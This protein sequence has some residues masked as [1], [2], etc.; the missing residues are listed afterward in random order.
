MVYAERDVITDAVRLERSRGIKMVEVRGTDKT[1]F[2]TRL[3]VDS[4]VDVGGCNEAASTK[5]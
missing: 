5:S 1:R 2:K 4:A 3:A